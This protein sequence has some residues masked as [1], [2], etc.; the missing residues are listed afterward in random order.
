MPAAAQVLPIPEPLMHPQELRLPANP[1]EVIINRNQAEFFPH[2]TDY[3]ELQQNHFY[4]HFKSVDAEWVL[5]ASEQ[6]CWTQFGICIDGKMIANIEVVIYR[7]GRS[8]GDAHIENVVVH[9]NYRGQ[10]YGDQIMQAVINF[11][12]E[13]GCKKILLEAKQCAAGL[14]IRSG[15]EENGDKS[16]ILVL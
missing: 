11:C 8:W 6:P 5:N 10:G 16:Y 15:F 1:G 13:Q 12:R 14:Y 7:T 3:L 2:L 9:G 4:P